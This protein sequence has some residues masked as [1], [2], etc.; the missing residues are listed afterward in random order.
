M[1]D[2]NDII[3]LEIDDAWDVRVK[4]TRISVAHFIPFFNFNRRSRSFHIFNDEH[5][6]N[7]EIRILVRL[8][9][10]RGV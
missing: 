3:Q 2:K 5:N 4:C 6:S 8:C 1:I 7:T 10:A 9:I